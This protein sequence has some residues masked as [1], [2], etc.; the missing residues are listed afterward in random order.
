M[1]LKSFLHRYTRGFEQRYGYDATYM[2]EM[3]DT[4]PAGFVRFAVMQHAGGTWRGDAPRD[5]W[6]AAG[7]AGA[8]VEDCGPCVQ[9]ASDMAMEAGMRGAVI[10]ALLSGRPTDADAQLG[11]DYG[12]ALLHGS[13]S[14]DDLRAAVE[15]KWGKTALLAI[16]LRAMTARNFPVLKRA[17]GHARTCQRVRIG[18]DDVA[19]S[20][21]L[22]DA[23]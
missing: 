14:L 17:L 3:T 2:H 5:V 22:K 18:N 16:S 15:T 21:T 23:A 7:I 13:A 10:A 8:L 1:M 11:F 19:V 9:I 12:R 20:P 6:C 4:S